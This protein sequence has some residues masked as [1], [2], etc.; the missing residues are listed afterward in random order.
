MLKRVTLQKKFYN[1]SAYAAV[2][3]STW[4]LVCGVIICPLIIGGLIVRRNGI[5]IESLL[6]EK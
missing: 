3:G 4:N 5:L 6:R 2:K 1:I